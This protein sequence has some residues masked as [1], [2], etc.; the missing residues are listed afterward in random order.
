MADMTQ[1]RKTYCR[2]CQAFCALEATVEDG[3]VVKVRGD[4]SDPLTR[5]YVCFKGLR[6]PELHH[7]PERITTS[8][9]RGPD[10]AFVPIAAERAF[11]EISEKLRAIIEEDGPRA[12]AVFLGT[13]GNFSAP[14]T[15]MA[16]SFAAAIGSPCVFGTTTIDQSA[17]W[18]AT[19][20]I[21]KFGGGP[22]PF[23]GS[24][25][26]MFIGTNPVVSMNPPMLASYGSFN[27]SDC[28][29]KA[30]AAG[31]KLIVVDPRLT[32]TARHADLFIQPRPGEDASIIAAMIHVILDAGWQ[33]RAFC[34]RHV[35]GVE[36][37]SK[38]LR[39][40][41]P[42]RVAARADIP[43][44]QIVEAAELFAHQARRG[45][46][47]TGTGPDMA[48][49]SNLAEHLVQCLNA[50]CGRYLRAGEAVP[51]PGVLT[52]PLAHV[53][54]TIA[55]RREW[56]R[57]GSKSRKHGLGVSHGEMMSAVL[58]DEILHP[59]RGRIRAMICMGGNP[60]VALPDQRKA[61]EALRSLDLLVTIDPRMSATARLA[62]YVIAPTLPFER[63]DHTGWIDKWYPAPYAHY[64]PALV[65]APE[66]AVHDW[67]VFWSL[68]S[69]LGLPLGLAST[70]L[71]VE[72]P[73]SAD[74]LLD[75][76]AASAQV[77]LDV[78]KA[79]EGGRFYEVPPLVVADGPAEGGARLQLTS[80]DVL[81]EISAARH[82][83]VG[84]LDQV[85]ERAYP[86]RLVARRLREVMNSA[87]SDLAA[88]RERVPYNPAYMNPEDMAQ[89]GL[90]DGE[91]VRIIS[92]HDSVFAR[93][94]ADPMVRGGVIS[95]SHCWGG[96]PDDEA[97]RDG[98]YSATG[99]L[100]SAEWRAQSINRMPVMSA[101]PVRIERATDESSE[102]PPARPR[103]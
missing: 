84:G 71:Y 102:E 64:A 95:M 9:K 75:L 103:A 100:V 66:G 83:L 37:L 3:R 90:S 80:P 73:P 85:H 19:G 97:D 92:P 78:V 60:A 50:I 11:D 67:Y 61:V 88:T 12:V 48:S 17:K 46:A 96:L 31:M 53:E 57:A 1:V 82:E 93:V 23:E 87:G 62:H 91:R 25:I 51:N 86:M 29:K 30:R 76:M 22:Q 69:R 70:E 38:A 13:Q 16:R 4:K 59:G 54:T 79:A 36:N 65:A 68:A 33:D 28:L 44:S 5:G 52:A 2:V 15:G 35:D 55:A 26:W 41:T 32:E 99:R 21:G 72:V 101:I 43:A 56:D 39:D 94:K 14:N 18:I 89:G 20:R 42:E 58:A 77:P 98:R 81:E 10:G 27:P 74:D 40:F 45:M 7:G 63:P 34:E 24:D 8:L 49:H 6:S 47:T